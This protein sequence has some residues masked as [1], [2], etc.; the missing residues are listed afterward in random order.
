MSTMVT[1]AAGLLALVCLGA[2]PGSAAVIQAQSGS[3]VD[4]Q[5]AIAAA[6]R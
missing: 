3:S 5:A 6:R 1:A 2:L 4:L